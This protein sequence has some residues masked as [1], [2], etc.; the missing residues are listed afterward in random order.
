MRIVSIV[1][2]IFVLV[3]GSINPALAA[4][5]FEC[6]TKPLEDAQMAEVKALLPTIDAYDH[7]D[8]LN[9]AVTALKIA[10]AS[11]VL[12]IDRLIA[13][14]CPLVAAIPGLTDAQKS[15]QVTRFAAR[16][17]RAAYSLDGEDAIILDVAL[18]PIIVEA[19]NARAK[20]AGVSPDA[21]IQS[22]VA[23]ALQ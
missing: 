13:S 22:T 20:A 18:P 23:A 3:A 4:G 6:P 1:S 14:Y 2:V 11:P 7:I 10:G 19:I 21:W 16:I 5:P 9:S 17:T 8:Q 12:A 15:K